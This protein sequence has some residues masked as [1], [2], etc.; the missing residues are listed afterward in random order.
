MAKSQLRP[1]MIEK[2]FRPGQSGNPKGRPKLTPEQREL[3]KLTIETYKEVIELVLTGNLKEL[4]EMAEDPSTPAIQVGIAMSFMKAIKAGD[5]T[6]IERIA[7]RIVGKIPDL[8]HVTSQNNTNINTKVA[9][10]DR[11]LLKKA[12]TDIESDV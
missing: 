1:K 9:I 8:V 11:D 6:V 5:Y 3:R 2:M 7:E 12:L 10:I 4:K